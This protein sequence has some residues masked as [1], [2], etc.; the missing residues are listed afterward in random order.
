MEKPLYSLSDDRI[1]FIRADV[2]KCGI[3]LDNLE[4][5]LV[6]HL[7]CM[8]E[9]Y[10]TNGYSFE[11]AYRKVKRD[12]AIDSL[13]DIEIKTLLL[14]NKKF[15]TM[16]TTL[17]I[18]GI[19]GLVTILVA[20]V[21]KVCHWPGASILF[22]TGFVTL[23]FAYLPVLAFNLKREK[24]LKRQRDLSYVG[25]AAAFFILITI[26]FAI[27][28][29]PYK[30]YLVFISWIIVLVFLIMLFRNILKSEENRVLNF[31]VM[32]FLTLLFMLTISLYLINLGNPRLSRYTLEN[33]FDESIQ[34]FENKSNEAYMKLDNI[35]DVT[36]K[37]SVEEI[38]MNTAAMILRLEN[39]Q[40]ALFS[41]EAEK[42]SFNKKLFKKL[43]ITPEIELDAMNLENEVS[44]YRGSI[45]EKAASL[46]AL[47]AFINQSIHFGQSDFNNNSPVIYNNLS[48][49]IRDIRITEFIL[50]SE[51]YS[52]E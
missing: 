37:T 48:R 2:K 11:D 9:E 10:L 12:N 36:V 1:A 51:L 16:K 31:S 40:K 41:S 35:Q 47:Q 24:I 8:V 15:Q 39:F 20:S 50:V 17:K 7:C 43:V 4:E 52:R 45:L 29:W 13:K 27:M 25:I 6:D 23:A 18:T 49:L 3:S 5:E 30:D 22:L 32:L 44:V 33:N 26:F 34:L 28:H 38:R 42:S 14:I 19:A 21:F 46:P